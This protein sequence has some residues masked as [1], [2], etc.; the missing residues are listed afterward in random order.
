MAVMH[1]G[2]GAR[3]AGRSASVPLELLVEG[4]NLVHLAAEMLRPHLM[5]ITMQMKIP[6]GS[7]NM[8]VKR[9]WHAPICLV[10]V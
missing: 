8:H 9:F 4:P 7:L 10:Y 1:L 2:S 5:T 3:A 6:V